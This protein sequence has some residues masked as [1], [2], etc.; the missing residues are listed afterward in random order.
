LWEINI[1]TVAHIVACD[2][3]VR[4]VMQ[5]NYNNN[6]PTIFSC[7]AE[8]NQ[9]PVY[10]YVKNEETP[11]Q[12]V[13]LTAGTNWFSTYYDIPLADLQNA[14]NEALPSAT[15]M[16][17][18][19]KNST[20]RWNGSQWRNANG[21]VWDVA[22]MYMIVVPEDCELVLN[23]TLINPAEHTITI[24][25]GTPTWIGFP[26]SE[27]KTFSEAIPA[28]FAVSGDQIKYQNATARFNGTNWRGSAGFTGLEP[29]KGYMYVPASNVTTDRTLDYSLGTSKAVQTS[30][31]NFKKEAI[32]RSLTPKTMSKAFNSKSNVQAEQKVTCKKAKKNEDCK[33]I[34]K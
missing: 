10:L 27:S 26:F 12:T 20:S 7:Y 16:T 31:L 34:K 33:S 14:L 28:V 23:G 4:N 8:A 3:S 5:F 13:A 29:G 15:S 19:S 30:N 21:F 32:N 18:K 17:I 2:T 24:E 6:N 22:K 11:T 9:S 25:A 1:D